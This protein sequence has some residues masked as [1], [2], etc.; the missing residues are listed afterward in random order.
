[1]FAWCGEKAKSRDSGN[2]LLLKEFPG[3]SWTFT[4]SNSPASA[5]SDSIRYLILDDYDGFIE[6]AGSEGSP[7]DLFR[8]R[9]DAF[10]S[11][12]KIYIN[13][14]PTIAGTS[15]IEREYLES[16]QGEYHVPCPHCGEYQFLSFGGKGADHGIKFSRDDDGQITDVWYQC[17]ACNERIEEWQKTDMMA[18]GRYVHKYPDRKNGALKSIPFTLLSAG[19]PGTGS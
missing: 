3:G 16:S 7:G 11:K 2:T 6:D 8:R 9:T 17:I 13:S 4:G 19:C 18:K 1:M 5:R 12:R 15:N 10:G 14:T